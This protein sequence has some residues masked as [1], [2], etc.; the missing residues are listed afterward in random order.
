MKT[1]AEIAAVLRQSIKDRHVPQARLKELAGISQRTLT[2]VLSGEEDF[3]VSTLFALADRL[4]LELVLAP[5]QAAAA[6]AAGPATKPV[7]L[8]RVAAA[9]ERVAKATGNPG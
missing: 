4:G 9:L 8:S 7:V 1:H 3:K 5:K 6:V 2:N